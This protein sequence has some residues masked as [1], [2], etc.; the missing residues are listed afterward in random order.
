MRSDRLSQAIDRLAAEE[1]QFLSRQFLAPVLAGHPVRVRVAGVVC[2][3]QI[4]PRD[5]RGFGIFQPL[6]FEAARLVGAAQLA[7][8]RRYLALFPQVRLILCKP[9]GSEWLA[10][11]A[12]RGDRRFQ[13]EGLVPVRFVDEA[14]QFEIVRSRFDGGNFWFEEVDPAGNAARAAY[15][16][17]SLLTLV[18]PNQLE[19]RGLTP[20]ERAAYTI[21][22]C[23]NEEARKRT[24]AE[25]ARDRLR[26]ALGHAGA[27]LVDFHERADAFRVT[28]RVGDQKYVSA[29]EKDGLS[30]QVAGICL[31]GRDNEFDLA[32]LVGV[33][34]EA[35]GTDE[36]VAIGH[37]GIAE[38]HYWRMH[39]RE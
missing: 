23:V 14:E 3:L 27:E 18:A 24:A 36:I 33:I 2:R 4:E 39:P 6:S 15:L 9:D 20:E 22:Y 26:Q 25:L 17:Q 28:F 29:V 13:I 8:R 10:L 19:R 38:E 31:S 16:R 12:H 35:E 37:E 32:S 11:P 30:V 5:F 21:N 34:R 1:E 7:E